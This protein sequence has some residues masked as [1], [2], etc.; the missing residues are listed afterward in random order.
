MTSPS[1]PPDPA[2]PPAVASA[3]GFALWLAELA[4]ALRFFSRLPVPRLGPADDPARAPRFATVARVI[5][6]AGAVLGVPGALVAGAGV[7]LGL[8]PFV[9]AVFAIAALVAVTGAFHEDGLADTA[10]GFGGGWSRARKLEI[11]K[12]SRLGSYGAT[13]LVLV[14]LARAGLLA[15]LLERDALAAIL[16]LIVAGSVARAAA[17]ALVSSLPPARDTG[18][19]AAAGRPER[20]SLLIGSAIALGLAL[21]L[22]GPV[23]GP[24]AALAATAAAFLAASAVARLALRQIGGQTGDVAGAAEQAGEVA[25]ALALLIVLPV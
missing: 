14:L 18:A 9:I 4:A 6:L 24:G 25:F 16:M 22:L 10:D 23:A 3:G 13:A 8:P 20:A 5:P 11:M 1:S 7:L 2:V 21:A 15:A 12:D 17:L 19:A